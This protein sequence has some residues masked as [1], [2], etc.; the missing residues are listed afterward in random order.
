MSPMLPG[1]RAPRVLSDYPAALNALGSAVGRARAIAGVD[2]AGAPSR[3]GVAA[4]GPRRERQ[5]GVSRT[6]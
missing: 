1:R 3:A 2:A 5:L 4:L 6:G